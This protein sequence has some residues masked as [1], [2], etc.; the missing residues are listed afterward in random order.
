MLR[1]LLTL[2]ALLAACA[3]SH[4]P[5]S[6]EPLVQSGTKVGDCSPG[7]CKLPS[8]ATCGISFGCPAA[9]A[10]CMCTAPDGSQ[11]P[12]QVVR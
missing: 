3:C 6:T 8:G 11:V 9:G 5:Q 12:G 1:Y 4:A 2:V 10:L 7:Y